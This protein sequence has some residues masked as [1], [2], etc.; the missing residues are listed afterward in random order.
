MRKKLSSVFTV[1]KTTCLVNSKIYIGVH[2]TADPNDAYLGSG[3]TLISAVRKYGEASFTKE[4]LHTYTSEA[5]AYAKEGE[6]VTE[7]F[8]VRDDT[9]NLIPGGRKARGWY[10]ARGGGNNPQ[11]G[12]RWVV[13]QEGPRKI[14]VADLPTYL[15]NG[16][17][18]G[19]KLKP[20][21]PP[22]RYLQGSSCNGA[23]LTEELAQE[24]REKYALGG[25]T[26]RA[27]A[28]LYGVSQPAINYL[29]KCQTWSEVGVD[30]RRDRVVIHGEAAR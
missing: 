24:I 18:E 17:F 23:K 13:N 21:K 19:R 3:R 27:L 11:F 7:D 9:Y 26:Q 10:R 8:V 2:K 12:T 22:L 28:L 20:P 25:V 1:Y 6:L 5:A 30:P 15:A 14:Q 29:L 16:W 4:V